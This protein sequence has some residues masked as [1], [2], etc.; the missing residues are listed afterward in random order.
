MEVQVVINGKELE[1]SS[2]VK[3][4]RFMLDDKLQWKEQ[5]KEVKRKA[6][7]G[8]M[9]LRRLQH[10]LPTNTS[11]RIFTICHCLATPGLLLSCMVS[12]HRSCARS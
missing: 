11:R 7:A 9:S 5:V 1:R 2:L 6:C 8:L 10:V 3:C 4:L 12:A